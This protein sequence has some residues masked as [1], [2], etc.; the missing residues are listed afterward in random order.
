VLLKNSI[1]VYV[2]AHEL[3][4]ARPHFT[5]LGGEVYADGGGEAIAVLVVELGMLAVIAQGE[6]NHFTDGGVLFYFYRLRIAVVF[7]DEF[8]NV[9][10]DGDGVFASRFMVIGFR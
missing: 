8:F 9:G 10:E 3:A 5:L 6:C 1:D 4:Q 7:K 2:Q